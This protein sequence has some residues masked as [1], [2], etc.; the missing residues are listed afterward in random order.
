MGWQEVQVKRSSQ[1][2]SVMDTGPSEGTLSVGGRGG[3]GDA[4]LGGGRFLSQVLSFFR[5]FSWGL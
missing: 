3:L 1:V 4:F 2:D 5:G